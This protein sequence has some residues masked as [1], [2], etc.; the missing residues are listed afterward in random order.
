MRPCNNAAGR[1]SSKGGFDAPPEDSTSDLLR[2]KGLDH[3]AAVLEQYRSSGRKVADL[4]GV[5]WRGRRYS[6]HA[7]MRLGTDIVYQGMLSTDR[8][9]GIADF[10]EK[11][12]A[13]SDLGDYS[14]EVVDTKLARTAQPKHLLQ[15]S[16]YNMRLF[17]I[18]K[19]LPL[20]AHL[21][22]GDGRR[23]TF[24]S[25]DSKYYTI[26]IQ[27]RLE[28]F[29]DTLPRTMPEPC[30]HCAMCRWI[31]QCEDEWHRTRH[32]CVVANIDKLCI[33]THRSCQV[34]SC[35]ATVF[36]SIDGAMSGRRMCSPLVY[37]RTQSN[38]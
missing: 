25:L 33:E 31:T 3:E 23:E 10:L 19:L 12:H 13:P 21:I 29:V 7:A 15:L 30:G 8:W 24:R 37:I 5:N 22:Q 2:R 1:S 16:L 20:N 17:D 18:Q 32:L 35:S 27:Q 14:Y 26:K 34:T 4:S 28:L 9:L 36:A 11:T 6:T 38:L